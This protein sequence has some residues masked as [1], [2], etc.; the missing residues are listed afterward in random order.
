MSHGQQWSYN[1]ICHT[2][3]NGAIKSCTNSTGDS[4]ADKY[5]SLHKDLLLCM[6]QQRK[7]KVKE[8]KTLNA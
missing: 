1:I 2:D 6:A 3:N 4:S 8:C 5:N 7:I